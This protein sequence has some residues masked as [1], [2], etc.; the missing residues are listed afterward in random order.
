MNVTIEEIQARVR[1]WIFL[2]NIFL[3]STSRTEKIDLI[4]LYLQFFD[5]SNTPT[6]RQKKK[7][8]K[9]II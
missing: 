2:I 5:Q 9:T 3:L 7:I 6:A 8:K 4:H 1:G